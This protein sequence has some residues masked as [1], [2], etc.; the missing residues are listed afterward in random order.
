MKLLSGIQLVYNQY[1]TVN[2]KEKLQNENNFN[3]KA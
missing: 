2:L 3:R 1:T